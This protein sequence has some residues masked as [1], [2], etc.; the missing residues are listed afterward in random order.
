MAKGTKTGGGSRKGIPNKATTNAREAIARFV[1]GHM[2][3]ALGWLK[4]VR[5]DEGPSA[6]WNCFVKLLEF[7][8]PKLSRSELRGGGEDGKLVIEIVHF[9][10]SPS[11]PE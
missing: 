3:E 4:E 8:V 11:S 7:H 6:A 1:N 5:R 2:D 9:G 10:A